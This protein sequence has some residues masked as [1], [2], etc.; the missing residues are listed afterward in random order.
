MPLLLE[1]WL[2]N[3][4]EL[5]AKFDFAIPPRSLQVSCHVEIE[6]VSR[7]GYPS[8]LRELL[9]R[10]S[11]EVNASQQGVSTTGTNF[12]DGHSVLSNKKLE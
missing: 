1:L 6:R 7:A 12:N 11:T 5:V 8:F 9:F 3:L 4:K 10:D 2:T